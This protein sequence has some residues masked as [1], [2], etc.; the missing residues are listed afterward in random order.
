MKKHTID[1]ISD[2]HLSF[3]ISGTPSEIKLAHLIDI[4]IRKVLKPKGGDILVLAGDCEDHYNHQFM[5]L[6]TQLKGYYNDICIVGGNHSLYLISS[7]Q[8]KKYHKH[9]Y[10]RIEEMKE[11]CRPRE[12]IH[13]L[14]GDVVDINGLI[15]GGTMMWYNL[16]GDSRLAQWNEVMNDSNL[17]M[18][19]TEPIKYQYGYGGYYKVSQWDTQAHYHKEVANLKNMVN[20]D[21]DVLV[22]HILPVI[23]PDEIMVPQYRGDKNNI[24]YMSDNMDIVEEIN[25]E[26]VIFGHTH[27]NY[28]FELNDIRFVCNPLGYKSERTGNEIRQIEITKS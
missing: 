1:F 12:G 16:D 28:D 19:G 8:Q 25:P 27:E 23:M 11:W 13:Y 18:G 6:L 15:I 4:F 9:S 20:K 5:E 10:E 21:V 7:N 2:T 22:T 26:V 17:I 3:W 14:D 24:F